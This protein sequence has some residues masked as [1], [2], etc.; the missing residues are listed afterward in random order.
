MDQVSSPALGGVNRSYCVST[1]G[2][3]SIEG[4]V[5][6]DGEGTDHR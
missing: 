3:M 5:S 2:V 1:I 4:N 6:K